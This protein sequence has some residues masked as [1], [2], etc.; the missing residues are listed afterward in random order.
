M[1]R[2]SGRRFSDQGLYAGHWHSFGVRRALCNQVSGVEVA[3][4]N[5]VIRLHPRR[6]KSSALGFFNPPHHIFSFCHGLETGFVTESVTGR[7]RA[8]I[9]RRDTA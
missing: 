1:M 6:R 8:L 3:G 4:G 7:C 9:Q 2:L 5:L